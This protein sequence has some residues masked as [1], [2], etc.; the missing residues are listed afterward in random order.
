MILI[1]KTLASLENYEG[2]LGK[3]RQMAYIKLT[4]VHY[5]VPHAIYD[6][7]KTLNSKE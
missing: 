7:L 6:A 5:Q 2:T 1:S 3:V 4:A